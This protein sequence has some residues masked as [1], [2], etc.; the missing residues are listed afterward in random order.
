MNHTFDTAARA[1]LTNCIRE[2]EKITDA[3][4][5][6]VVRARS[7]SYRQADYLF[8]AL[9]A[10]VGLNFLLFSPF[11]FHRLWVP[12]DVAGLFLVG[13]FVSSRSNAIRRLLTRAKARKQSVRAAAAAMFYEAGIA[14]T[15]A[16]LGLLVF[17]S[18]FERRLEVI[19]DRGILKAVPALDWNQIVFELHES[20]KDPQPDRLID[21]LRKL[22][23][24]LAQNLPASK[25]NPNELPDEPR[26]EL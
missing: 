25:E 10:F 5:V 7:A 1:N 26:F 14:N 21:V 18:L 22:G 23:N 9:L 15:K 16:E 12:I 20:G 13:S 2:I 6:L 19:A 4:L 11:T 8:G 17:L 3:E 24:I